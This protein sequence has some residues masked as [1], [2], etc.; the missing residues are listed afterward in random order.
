MKKLLSILFAALLF[1]AALSAQTPKYVFLFIGDGMGNN[2]AYL[3]GLYNKRTG[4]GG[5]VNFCGFPVRALVSTY[6][7]SSL[8]TDSSAAGTA[9]SSGQKVNN[10]AM[11]WTP[12]GDCT[13]SVAET[14]KRNGWGAG[15]VTSVGVNHATPG[16]FY[17]H[18][19]S[20]NQY[21]DIAR[22]LYASEIDFAAGATLLH[23]KGT[24]TSELIDAAKQAG[25]QVFCGR[26][27]YRTVKGGRVLCLSS[28]PDQSALTY[29]IDRK[30]DETRLADFTAEAIDH[31]YA[32]YASKGFFLMVEGGKIDYAC[33]ARDAGTTFA[34]I[35]DMA[36]SVELALEFAAKHPKQTLIIVTADHE[37]GSCTVTH[38]KYECYPERYAS[39]VCSK[40][41]VTDAIRSLR[42]ETGN[43]PSWW[44]I[45]DILRESLGL[46]DTVPVSR[47]QE[48]EFTQI[49]KE[50]YLDDDKSE[51][52]NLYSTNERIV[53][54]A[55]DCLDTW[56]GISWPYGN[57]SGSPVLLY[58]YGAGAQ[59]FATCLDNTDIPKTIAKVAKFK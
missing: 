51:E 33:H 30:G 19:P 47:K 1:S 41:A 54:A 21:D 43:K 34:E 8:V 37:T 50:S 15:V 36:E 55:F 3:T 11:G 7:A 9:L 13:V 25:L 38:G 40:D 39:Q 20:R 53:A 14:A 26:D 42:R 44:Q 22:Q 5:D 35:N 4:A 23:D 29:A 46:W 56:A 45:K 24:K 32:N 52:V 28:N 48:A 49:Y 2:Q 6:S 16:A 57:H 18:V 12:E 59:A 17:A 58:A 10:G 31:L 27:E